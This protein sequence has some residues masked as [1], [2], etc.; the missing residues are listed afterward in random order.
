MTTKPPPPWRDPG[1]SSSGWGVILLVYG[2]VI[3]MVALDVSALVGVER[4]CS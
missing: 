2:I 3:L 4:A 1:S